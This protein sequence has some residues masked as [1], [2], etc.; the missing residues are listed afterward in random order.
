MSKLVYLKRGATIRDVDRTVTDD[1]YE[2]NGLFTSA[3]S[4]FSMCFKEIK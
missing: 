4:W 1:V 2:L 3:S